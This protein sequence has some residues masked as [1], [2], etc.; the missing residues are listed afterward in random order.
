MAPFTW[1]DH[2]M[3]SVSVRS[4]CGRPR[5][6]AS[7][8]PLAGLLFLAS[9]TASLATAQTGALDPRGGPSGTAC[10]RRLK[11]PVA[12]WPSA[13]A[14]RVVM[15]L[16]RK[17]RRPSW[18]KHFG[19]VSRRKR[20]GDLLEF[21]SANMP[22]GSPRFA[23]P[24]HL[25]GHRRADAEIQRLSRGNRRAW[26]QHHRRRADYPSGRKYGT[27]CQRIRSRGRLSGPQRSGLGGHQRDH[28]RAGGT[29][30]SGRRRRR[31]PLGSRTMPLKFVVTSLDS[32]AGSRV[33]VSGLLIGAGGVDGINVT[34]VSRVAPKCP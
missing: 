34:A 14:A 18:A 16:R 26:A 31:R 19:R 27:P 25:R 10:T 23:Q 20:V 21:V 5:P 3:Q 12:C 2:I 1:Q 28:P 33:A 11:P 8:L 22:N 30:C 6:P 29:R 13:K 7:V 15:R 17:A 4:A 24:V 32:L 9:A